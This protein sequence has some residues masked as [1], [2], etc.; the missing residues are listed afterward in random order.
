[1]SEQATSI[2]VD[3][4]DGRSA[5]PHKVRVHC[6]A[7]SLYLRGEG[8][9]R[10]VPLQEVQWPERTR[11]GARVAHLADGSSLHTRD[12]AAWDAWCQACG[13]REG[14]VSRA[15]GSWRWVMVAVA[16]LVLL[17]A[18][19]YRWGLPAVSRAVVHFV[20]AS[21]EQTLG[22]TAYQSIAP[23]LLRPTA[24]SAAR[25]EDLR[26][27]FDEAVRR[28]YPAGPPAYRL[29]FHRSRIGPN[30]FALPGGTIVLTD[31]LVE[32]MQGDT[33]AIIGVLAHELGHVEHRHGMRMLVQA[34]VLGAV[35]S[36]AFGDFSGWLATAPVLLGQA[37]YSREAEREADRASVRIL[38]AAGISP[39]V[40]V[41]FFEK[42]RS[43]DPD[44]EP[45]L[46]GIAFSSHPA[47]AQRIRF[48]REAA[49]QR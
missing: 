14:W 40:M 41:R 9:A 16:A 43:R 42:V 30:A 35:A 22:D 7:A 24:L 11:H 17:T 28:A 49:G 31:E 15:Q 1:M 3:Y 45:S 6:D 23:Q 21:V 37:A 2:E 29:Y 39:E 26:R 12:A 8:V 36:L 18:V 48:F 13:H 47:D 33:E 4:F 10:R 38:R 25:Q 34:G 46:L 44:R 20:P 32:L 5:R 19:M 27:A